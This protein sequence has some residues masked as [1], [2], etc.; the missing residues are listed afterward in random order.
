[1]THLASRAQFIIGAAAMTAVPSIVTAA[2]PPLVR[3]G[4][5]PVDVSAVVTYAQELG[6]FKAAG[7]DVQIEVMQSGP[8]IAPAVIGG[9]LDAGAMNSGSLAGARERG[10][11]LR[12]FAPAAIASPSST[13]DVI[14]V[15]SD[16]PIK[17][18]ADM[19]G[20]TVAIVAMK[21][22]QHAAV[23][24]WVDKHGGDS[25]TLKF[26]EVPFP[27]MIGTLDAGRVDIAI[28][29][30]PFTSQG[31][32]TNR[33]IGGAYEA[34]PG[35]ILLFGFAATDAWLKANPDTAAKFA[36]AISKAGAWANGHAKESAT[37]LT[38]FAKLDP[39]VASTM[40][41]ARYATTIDPK[42]VQPSVDL[43]VRYGMLPTTID[44][45]EL[46]WRPG[47]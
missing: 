20:K 39:K 42:M 15:R 26:I 38:A 22:V 29:S 14:M 47:K 17:T 11:P 4:T 3:V 5:I 9:T 7:L 13:S 34:L 36:D 33:T 24:L 30:E 12:Y 44:A 31:R 16:S 6:Y 41:R 27:E 37:M 40:A 2:T 18:G 10:L 1:M 46:I 35:P 28:P 32:A 25:K 21:T 23:L 43:M 45:T 19:N 8:V